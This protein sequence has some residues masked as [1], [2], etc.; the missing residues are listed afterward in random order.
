[1]ASCPRV[2][3]CVQPTEGRLAQHHLTVSAP[4]RT[5]CDGSPMTVRGGGV[6][7]VRMA[8]IAVVQNGSAASELRCDAH[9]C[10][11]V[12]VSGPPHTRMWTKFVHHTRAPLERPHPDHSKCAVVLGAVKD[13][14][15]GGAPSLTAPARARLSIRVG[16]GEET[17]STGRIRKS[18][19]MDRTLGAPLD[20]I[21]PIQAVVLCPGGRSGQ[22]VPTA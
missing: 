3:S 19:L 13:E 17:G 10:I 20:K 7:H 4:V 12:R 5:T 11:M 21:R 15:C 16:R 6:P 8:S 14:P 2:S 22:C 9:H 18:K 1:M